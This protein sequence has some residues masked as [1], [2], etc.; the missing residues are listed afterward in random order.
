MTSRRRL[1]VSDLTRLKGRRQLTMLR[2][3]TLDEAAA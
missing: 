1:T 2:I 3:F